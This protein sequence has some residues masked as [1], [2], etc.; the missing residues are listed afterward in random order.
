M[1]PPAERDRDRMLMDLVNDM[2][3][4]WPLSVDGADVR[5]VV[6]EM[7]RAEADAERL[8]LLMGGAVA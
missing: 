2:L 6:G 1:G 8:G 7:S 5:R 3:A 4:W